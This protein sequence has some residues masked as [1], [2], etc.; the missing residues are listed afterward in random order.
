MAYG[1]PSSLDEV[2]DYLAQVRGGRGSSPDEIEHLKQRYQRVGGQTPLLQITKSQADALQKKLIA[3]DTPAR[4]L[5]G[6]KHWHPFVEDV[7][8]K[9]GIDNPPTLIGLALTPLYSKLSIG[10]YEQSG[11]RGLARTDSNFAFFMVK[12]WA[13]KPAPIMGL[14]NPVSDG[15]S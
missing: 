7:V 4:V 1:S 6:M 8:E 13:K 14:A 10:G 12:S 3:D 11:Q 15:V 9:I 5:F 2:G